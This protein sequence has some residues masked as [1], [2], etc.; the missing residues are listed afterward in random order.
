LEKNS[1]LFYIVQKEKFK[2]K[3]DLCTANPVRSINLSKQGCKVS[4][5]AQ[6][7][8][9]YTLILIRFPLVGDRLIV[10]F[11]I[12]IG[13]ISGVDILTSGVD[14]FIGLI[15]VAPESN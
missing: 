2:R 3:F 6:K 9:N 1:L 4:D 14:I 7:K 5:G 15:S 13:L 11:P 8:A 10:W 12:M